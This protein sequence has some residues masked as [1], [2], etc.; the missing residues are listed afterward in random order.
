MNKRYILAID[1]G[2]QSVRALL[3][4]LEGEL[5]GK[6]KVEIEPYFSAQPGWAEQDPEYY[7]RSLGEAC[8]QLWQQ[9]DVSPNE[10]LAA[11]V[12]TQRGTVINVDAEGQPLRPAIVW[13]DQRHAA[14]EG[15]VPGPWRWDGK[16]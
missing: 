15:K 14:L 3:F 11:T 13:L 5:I 12:T 16:N 7:W 4:D 8:E 10:V 6:G 1:N 9:V 2:T